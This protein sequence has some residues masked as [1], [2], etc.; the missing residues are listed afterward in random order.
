VRVELGRGIWLAMNQDGEAAAPRKPATL[1]RG[2]SVQ[3]VDAAGEMGLVWTTY[4]EMG[5][6]VV[7]MKRGNQGRE[8]VIFV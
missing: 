3:S 1:G 7:K 4:R 5:S 8:E 6:A 2:N